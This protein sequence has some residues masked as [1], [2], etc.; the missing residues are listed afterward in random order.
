MTQKKTLL[1]LKIPKKELLSII[2][3]DYEFAQ[4]LMNDTYRCLTHEVAC[5]E[6]LLAIHDL[7]GPSWL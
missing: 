3:P 5:D 1:K 2:F 4:C 6:Q 7:L